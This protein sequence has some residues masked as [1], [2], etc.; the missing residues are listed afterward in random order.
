M[1]C[2]GFSTAGNLK[3]LSLV[4]RAAVSGSSRGIPLK[5]LAAPRVVFPKFFVCQCWQLTWSSKSNVRAV[6]LVSGFSGLK[7]GSSL[8]RASCRAPGWIRG[9]CCSAQRRLFMFVYPLQLLR[10]SA[11]LRRGTSLTKAA[12]PVP[13]VSF[14]SVAVRVPDRLELTVAIQDRK[15]EVYIRPIHWIWSII[16]LPSM[17]PAIT[18]RVFKTSRTY[19]SGPD[20]RVTAGRAR[21]RR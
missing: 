13:V 2:I 15:G 17:L 7:R 4:I 12:R 11:K 19:A 9:C 21:T 16:F 20:V 14:L 10:T 6:V 8:S 18:A 3:E 1:V 5:P